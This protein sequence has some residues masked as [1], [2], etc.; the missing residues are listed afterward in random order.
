MQLI[1]LT[2]LTFI[3]SLLVTIITTWIFR[4]YALKVGLVAPDVR[5]KGNPMV[6]KLGGLVIPVIVP[7][8]FIFA[9]FLESNYNGAYNYIIAFILATIIGYIIGILDD[10]KVKKWDFVKIGAVAL[11]A[12]PLLLWHTYVPRPQIPIVG[13]LRITI[14]YPILM[15]IAFAIVANGM[16]MLDLVNGVMLFSEILLVIT[17]I[18]WSWLLG[19]FLSLE[20]ATLTLGLLIGLFIFNRYPAKLFVSNVGSYTTGVIGRP[21]PSTGYS[22]V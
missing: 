13:R 21:N 11:A 17:I 9:P 19:N 10:L 16:N 20:I 15:F 18:F 8:L 5:K 7:I 22:H 4:K 6:P 3:T 2:I 14:F 12:L 1:T